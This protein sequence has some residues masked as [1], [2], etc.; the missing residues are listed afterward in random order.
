LRDCLTEAMDAAGLRAVLTD[1]RAG[2]IKTLARE[3]PEPSVFAHEIL[4]ANPYAF[5]DDAPLEERR[6]RAVTL[7]RGLPA[8]TV[9]RLGTLDAARIDEVVAEAQAEARS[10]DELHDLLLDLGGAPEPFIEQRDWRALVETLREA[11]RAAWMTAGS[12]RFAVATE[13]RTLAETVWPGATFSP[14]VAEPPLRRPRAWSDRDGALAEVIRGHL[15]FTG[16][17][18]T[19]LLAQRLHLPPA[20]VEGALARV[21][22]EGNVLRGRFDARLPEDPD[23]GDR[24]W[25]DRRLLARINRRMLDGL[26]REIE[27]V[28]PADYLR[29]LLAWQHAAPGTEVEGRAGLLRVIEQLQG[30]EAAAGAWERDILPARVR[31]YDPAWL[32]ALCLAGDVTWGRLAGR[33]A[34]IAPNRTATIALVRRR[35]LTWLLRSREGLDDAQ[36]SPAARDVMAV[37]RDHG[38]SFVDD[39]VHGARRLRA[40]VEDALW[41]L[42]G[43]G[44]VTGDGFA[45]LR[46]LISATGS[47]GSTR[48]RWHA[49]WTR[50][51]GAGAGAASGVGT[52][53]W[54]VLRPLADAPSDEDVVEALA[55]QYLRRYGVVLRE[56]LA[57]EPQAPPWREVLRALRRLEMRGEIRGGRL[58]AGFVGEQFAVPEALESLRALRRAS[59]DGQARRNEVVR[60]SACDPLNLGGILTPGERTPATLGHHVLLRDG[61]PEAA[62]ETSTPRR[63][64]RPAPGASEAPSDLRSL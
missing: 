54:A 52:G 50:R 29:F 17:T 16:P 39:I 53:R 23:Y 30:F 36:L 58:V 6:T 4:N 48:L 28:S 51:Q 25:C 21:E 61:V 12:I 20:D 59:A 56:V 46:A 18:T 34:A 35:D 27:P 44:R 14:D 64:R 33:E 47:R 41:E 32:D 5:L 63:A 3:L 49:R 8:E 42:V 26:R 19:A 24:Q 37:L 45:G 1:I 62:P 11:G 60:L 38:A 9:E 22:L 2:R 7:R 10:A 57:R 13:R 40:E 55:R 43:A 31:R 15:V